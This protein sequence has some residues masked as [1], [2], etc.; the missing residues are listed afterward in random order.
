[1]E[2]RQSGQGSCA[3]PRPMA[4]TV[5]FGPSDGTGDHSGEHKKLALRDSIGRFA[6]KP[7]LKPVAPPPIIPPAAVAGAK[8]KPG[9]WGERRNADLWQVGG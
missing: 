1:M 8:L 5:D 2:D 4:F 7:K 3:S 6:P 9:E